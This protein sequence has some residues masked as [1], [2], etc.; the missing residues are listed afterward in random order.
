MVLAGDLN[1]VGWRRQLVT[2]QTG[3]I[4][5]EVRR[6]VD[7]GGGG[8]ES[9]GR[10][11]LLHPALAQDHRGEGEQAL[12]PGSLTCTGSGLKGSWLPRLR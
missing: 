8:E 1:L 5:D 10:P 12:R 2:I 9:P 6:L 4:L 3:D 11:R 7:D